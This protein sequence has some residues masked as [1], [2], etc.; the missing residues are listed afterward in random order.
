MEN[1]NNLN[2]DF[3][4]QLLSLFLSG[5]VQDIVDR[6]RLRTSLPS[7]AQLWLRTS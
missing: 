5:K 6:K 7:N 2:I 1:A 4:N 3:I